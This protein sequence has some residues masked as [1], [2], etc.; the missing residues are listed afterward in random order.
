MP[1]SPFSK[2]R[3]AV[4]NRLGAVLLAAVCAM[5]AMPGEGS[6]F[7][8]DGALRLDALSASLPA[9]GVQRVRFTADGYRNP[10]SLVLTNN[11]CDTLV[12]ERMSPS[13]TATLRIQGNLLRIKGQKGVVVLRGLAL[14]LEGAGA[15]FDTS[16]G[17]NH[18][19]ILDGCTL[20]GN[21]A[22]PA[23]VL[24]WSG[25]GK[26]S[27]SNCMFAN[28]GATAISSAISI[29]IVNSMFVS[30]GPITLAE[31]SPSGGI[32]LFNNLF[33]FPGVVSIP[34]GG[35]IEMWFNTANRTQFH[36]DGDSTA[37]FSIHNNYFANPPARNNV[38][39]AGTARYPVLLKPGSYRT[40]NS[41]AAE[42][43]RYTT[44][45]GF[46]NPT[47]TP[48]FGAGNTSI[49]PARDSTVLWDWRIPSNTAQGA[50]NGNLPL[51][52][53]NLFPSDTSLD[54]PIAGGRAIVAPSPFP[55]L[56]RFTLKPGS[57]P[58]SAFLSDSTRAW[59]RNDTLL[60]LTG[61]ATVVGLTLPN[62][63]NGIPLLFAH[64]GAGYLP[65]PPGPRGGTWFRNSQP[66]AREFIPALGG[67]NTFRGT[68]VAVFN[69]ALPGLSLV[70]SSVTRAGMTTF[71]A[72]LTRP[73]ERKLRKPLS[74]GR[75]IAFTAATTA[76]GAGTVRFGIPVAGM[77]VF[78]KD[79]LFFWRGGD[80]FL[81]AKDSAGGYWATVQSPIGKMEAM[82]VERMTFG[83]GAD[84][85]ILPQARILSNSLAG[86][87]LVADSGF[88]VP[89]QDEPAM[90]A[91]GAA[92]KFSWP[93]RLPGDSLF[94]LFPQSDSR[95]QVWI[96]RGSE[97]FP[98]PRLPGDPRSLRVALAIGD[99]NQLVF[100]ARKF[101]ILGGSTVNLAFGSDSVLG[102]FSPRPGD[103]AIESDFRPTNL[104][105]T[106]L[107]ILAARRILMDSLVPQGPYTLS[108]QVRTPQHKD[109]VRALVYVN[110]VWV[111]ASFT[112]SGGRYA[113]AVP[114]SAR[115]AMM[116]EFPS[117][118]DW[119][120]AQPAAKAGME[121]R[122][123]S[124]LLA[125]G[126]TSAERAALPWF[127]ADLL[128]L[129]S[130][131]ILRVEASR[132]VPVESSLSVGLA[133]DRLYAYRV[134]YRSTLDRFSPD[135]DWIPLA[136]K[137]PSLASIEDR[138]P[139]RKDLFRHLIGFP[140]DGATVGTNIK[141]GMDGGAG[142]IL[143][144][145]TLVSGKWA[146][147][148]AADQTRL[149][150]GKGYLLA[151]GKPFRPKAQGAV[152]SG[153]KPDTLRFDRTGWHLIASPLPFPFPRSAL[154]IPDS[155][156]LSFPRALRRLDTAAGSRAVYAWPVPDTL[157]PFEGYLLYVFK[158]TY[159]A[160]N[161]YSAAA[162]GGMDA[163]SGAPSRA[164]AE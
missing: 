47:A 22:G 83:P 138:V 49:S 152:F 93:G 12:F 59:F 15:L 48:L 38:I 128:S 67:Q 42:N 51:P 71:G 56:L 10:G 82:L 92:L 110:T 62:L 104:D 18:E 159:L 131:G 29:S 118:E 150:R 78:K 117:L 25:D 32:S 96:R 36:L 124:L 91:F 5:G 43:V 35:R 164:V 134:V 76:E 136:G 163:A 95:Q 14:K 9:T 113:I 17:G 98:L 2:N 149:E 70:F 6:T 45:D 142:E 44:W 114:A 151:S 21:A 160:F 69:P 74:Q 108:L 87:Q 97:S 148:P 19:L 127:R 125:P 8:I 20:L 143:A 33:N 120:P 132:Y 100:V 53:F 46:E 84:S 13:D 63:D 75:E 54:L 90:G 102:L 109:L 147:L 162:I 153:L 141:A 55:R 158:P 121:M 16:M 161:P 155:S 85:V 66:E 61:N 37:T 1:T 101:A 99:S 79:S 64:A 4:R 11:G 111:A 77:T 39:E 145:D 58:Y 122:G 89:P 40:V 41:I 129:G 7:A 144:L 57:I 126:L 119:A 24:A 123:D 133:P 28:M 30:T 139:V 72:L 88:R 65:G 94:A 68:D 107:T 23:K 52:A 27:L 140:F 3:A 81:P 73:T 157:Q 105:T 115:A 112:E 154:G 137:Q 106:R 31:A 116:V 50:W 60:T 34:M 80:L 86:H 130:S 146:G 156:A 26:V 103:L 135:L